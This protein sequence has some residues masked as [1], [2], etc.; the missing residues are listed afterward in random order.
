[1]S[2][3]Y[4]GVGPRRVPSDIFHYM[5]RLAYR[6]QKLNFILRTGGAPGANH[7]FSRSVPYGPLKEVYLPWAGFNNNQSQLNKYDNLA[8]ELA[9]KYHPAWDKLNHSAQKIMACN[10]A[11]VLG[12]YLNDPVQFVVTWTQDGVE[13]HNTTPRTGESG[14]IIRL[15]YDRGIPIFNLANGRSRMVDLGHF[16]VEKGIITEI[17]Q[18]VADRILAQEAE[19]KKLMQERQKQLAD[20]QEN[21]DGEEEE[22][23]DEWEEVDEDEYDPDDPDWEY[24]DIR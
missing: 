24:E 12:K 2:R 3:C 14:Q 10:V 5:S 6:L 22:D 15:A 13:D 21:K 11:Q 8:F 17:K 1:M 23:D 9:E 19:H 20:K 18:D 7:A 16:L 4:A